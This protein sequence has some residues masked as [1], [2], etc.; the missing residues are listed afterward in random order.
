MRSYT[1]AQCIIDSGTGTTL[2]RL[3][4]RLD[5]RIYGSRRLEPTPRT[6]AFPAFKKRK[7][8]G[9]LW[10]SILGTQSENLCCYNG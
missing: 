7:K 8:D 5:T 6:D 2:L 1:V 10:R 9:P 3:N 4:G